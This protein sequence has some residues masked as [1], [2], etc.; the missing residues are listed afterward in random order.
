MFTILL[1]WI[2]AKYDHDYELL[3]IGTVILDYF[4]ILAIA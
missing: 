3:F 4:L 2:N 1:A